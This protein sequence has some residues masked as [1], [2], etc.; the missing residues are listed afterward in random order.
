M[1]LGA[2][3]A[4]RPAPVCAWSLGRWCRCCMHLG[5]SAAAQGRR[6]LCVLL[7][8]RCVL[9]SLS[10]G[11]KVGRWRRCCACSWEHWLL[12]PVGCRCCVRLGAGAA[13]GCTR[14]GCLAALDAGSVRFDVGAAAG[15]RSRVLLRRPCALSF[16]CWHRCCYLGSMLAYLS[17]ARL[18]RRGSMAT[19][20][21]S[22]VTR[23]LQRTQRFGK[24][25]HL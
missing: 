18:R 12:V 7:E 9:G 15:C 14:L 13:A 22:S 23:C 8:A 25:C 11:A 10:A 5:A 20:T 17:S 24:R 6:L 19:S 21:M 16:G 3:A 2:G 1:R 4:A